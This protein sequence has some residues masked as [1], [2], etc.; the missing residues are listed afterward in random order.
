MLR[1]HFQNL[2][3]DSKGKL[4]HFR[5]WVS[6]KK[7]YNREY[8]NYEIASGFK[9]YYTMRV[10]RGS[11]HFTISL[12]FLTLY[13]TIQK[14][15]PLLPKGEY[16]VTCYDGTLRG[17]LAYKDDWHYHEDIGKGYKFM[18]DLYRIFLGNR[19]SVNNEYELY[20]RPIKFEFRGVE[21]KATIKY[22]YGFFFRSHLPTVLFRSEFRSISIEIVDMP[23]MQFSGKGT[24]SYNCD[25]DAI[26]SSSF[27]ISRE[28]MNKLGKPSHDNR[29]VWARHVIGLYC[30]SVHKYILKY[31]RST[32]DT[33]PKDIKDFK[34]LG[35][36]IQKGA[37]NGVSSSNS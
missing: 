35:I 25:D 13:L 7:N 15:L 17:Y 14:R 5:G 28:T 24:T 20:G 18:I 19:Y 26:Y 34:F 30:D 29:E 31:G 11:T 12:L 10:H 27:G 21:Y 4:F 16:G 36:D 23:K 6:S 3:E 22:S 1:H 37:D 33:T 32:G 2:K 8:F 9:F